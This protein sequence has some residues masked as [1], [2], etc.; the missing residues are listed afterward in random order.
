MHCGP[1]HPSP[2]VTRFLAGVKPGGTVL[3]VACGSGRHLRHALDHGFAV[4]G[5][6]R[7]LS[8]ARDL[9]GH[10]RVT[11]IETD[12]EDGNPF[13]LAGQRFDCVL[14]TN[15]LWRPLF[16]DL[17]ACV[18]GDGVLIY[19]TFALGHQRHGKPSRSEFL[20]G[21]NELLGFV[22]PDLVVVAYEHGE[23]AGAR[24]RIVQRIAACGRE[25]RWATDA[26]VELG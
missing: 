21:P 3:D 18:A 17:V 15:Y 23:I 9:E 1:K 11:L 25:H 22:L 14:V 8:D 20:L 7:D 10:G 5:V 13:P 6:D 19:E 2:W 26:P 24:P 12:L 16:P 4:T